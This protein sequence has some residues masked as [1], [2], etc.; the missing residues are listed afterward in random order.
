MNKQNDRQPL[1]DGGG[2]FGMAAPIGGMGVA[3]KGMGAAIERMGATI[4]GMG[5]DTGKSM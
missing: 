3:I 2:H 5:A 1:G 4:E